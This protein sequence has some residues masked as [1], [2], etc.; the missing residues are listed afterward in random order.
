MSKT[1]KINPPQNVQ[2]IIQQNFPPFVAPYPNQPIQQLQGQQIVITDV[3]HETSFS[4]HQQ[5][6]QNNSPYQVE[7]TVTQ[8]KSIFQAPIISPVTLEPRPQSMDVNAPTNTVKHNEINPS[9]ISPCF[10][11]S[12]T[13]VTN[14]RIIENNPFRMNKGSKRMALLPQQAQFIYSPKREGKVNKIENIN[15]AKSPT[16]AEINDKDKTK[17]SLNQKGANELRYKMAVKNIATVLKANLHNIDVHSNERLTYLKIA[18]RNMY[19][20]FV[21]K[22]AKQLREAGKRQKELE[23]PSQVSNLQVISSRKIFKGTQSKRNIGPNPEPALT[24]ITVVKSRKQNIEPV[25]ENSENDGHIFHFHP[26]SKKRKGQIQPTITNYL[27]LTLEQKKEIDSKAKRTIE[28]LKLVVNQE[29]EEESSPRLIAKEPPFKSKSIKDYFLVEDKNRVVAESSEENIN[30]TSMQLNTGDIAN[31]N[32]NAIPNNND[33]KEEYS[34]IFEVKTTEII[35]SITEISLSSE[36]FLENFEK[37]LNYHGV[38]SKDDFVPKI[39]KPSNV[40]YTYLFWVNYVDYIIIKYKNNSPDQ[41]YTVAHF[42]SILKQALSY[43]KEEDQS[44]YLRYMTDKLAV[45]FSF[46]EM[47]YF[48][49]TKNLERVEELVDLAYKE[50]MHP[51]LLNNNEQPKKVAKV[52]DCVGV[53]SCEECK[54]LNERLEKSENHFKQM[55]EDICKKVDN[56]SVVITTTNSNLAEFFKKTDSISQRVDNFSTILANSSI[57]NLNQEIKK[58]PAKIGN[59]PNN[60]DADNIDNIEDSDNV[61]MKDEDDISKSVRFIS[62]KFDK[63]LDSNNQVRY[64]KD[65]TKKKHEED[66]E[67]K[68]EQSLSPRQRKNKKN[69]Q[70]QEK[71]DEEKEEEEDEKEEEKEKTKT[72]SRSNVKKTKIKKKDLSSSKQNLEEEIEKIINLEADKSED[73]KDDKESKEGK[74]EKKKKEP[75]DRSKN[76]KKKKDEGEKTGVKLIDDEEDDKEDEEEEEEAKNKKKDKKDKPKRVK[77]QN[78]KQDKKKKK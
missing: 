6:F 68:R 24:Q 5:Q 30:T 17:L 11:Q 57:A 39:E 61:D 74:T 15:I 31:I 72:R 53:R 12:G 26:S 14:L 33:N 78:R 71:I 21:K 10:G 66:L 29:N 7:T 13:T 36:N 23:Q 58:T 52:C 8:S 76:G 19:Y 16:R 50:V 2:N 64:P 3:R 60:D 40:V 70:K 69:R 42:Y 34:G 75:R 45:T 37:I 47:E 27:P 1:N 67:K 44:M 43:L 55:W 25:P 56:I 54:K 49:R 18:K 41:K 51:E 63:D 77:S 46:R 62:K 20:D 9:P 59:I 22:F 38:K 32:I 4:E 48:L 35:P 65:D 73:E 28:S